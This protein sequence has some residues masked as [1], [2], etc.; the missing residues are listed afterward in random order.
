MNIGIHVPFPIMVFSV[1][2]P[3]S[4]VAGSYVSFIP[5]CFIYL[6]FLEI[7]ILFSIVDV[8]IY[9]PTN[10]TRGFLFLHILSKIYCLQVFLM[11]VI[12]YLKNFFIGV[13][14]IYNIVLVSSVQ[15]SESV[16]YICTFFF[17]IPFLYRPLQST[18]QSSIFFI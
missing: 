12:I 2:M 4:A 10:C 18:E 11:V 8:S 3:N 14:L 15:Q 5:S 16:I 9:I 7:S 1:Y 6:F 13:Q 17:T